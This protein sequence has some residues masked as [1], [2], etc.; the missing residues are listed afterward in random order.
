M[1][2][3]HCCEVDPPCRRW[4]VQR[5]DGCKRL[6]FIQKVEQLQSLF[7]GATGRARPEARLGVELGQGNGR[8]L[9]DQLIHADLAPLGQLPEAFM[10]LVG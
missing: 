6:L 7:S 10:F 4:R 2:D 1:L 8:E 9:V 3:E 5:R